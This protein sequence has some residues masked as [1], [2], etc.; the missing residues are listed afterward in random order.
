[1]E[2]KGV[3]AELNT[4]L[5]GKEDSINTGKYK[6]YRKPS[7]KKKAPEVRQTKTSLKRIQQANPL[8]QLTDNEIVALQES[9]TQSNNKFETGKMT[10]H[11][12]NKKSNYEIKNN[13]KSTVT[14]KQDGKDVIPK[15]HT[16]VDQATKHTSASHN[17]VVP[18]KSK[19]LSADASGNCIR[20][21][22]SAKYFET[23]KATAAARSHSSEN[24][25]MNKHVCEVS[26]ILEVSKEESLIFRT[27]SAYQR[28]SVARFT[29]STSSRRS[30][31]SQSKILPTL[32]ELQ[33]RLNGWLLKRG[34]NPTTFAYL[35]QL[36]GHKIG[37]EDKENV[38]VNREPVKAG[39][40]EDLHILPLEPEPQQQISEK[41]IEK[42]ARD[43]LQDL[44]QL[45]QEEYPA[46]HCESWLEL[47]ASKCEK[48]KDDPQYWEC[49]AKI[50][51][52]RGNVGD[53][54]EHYKTA[55]IQGAEVSEVDK[56]LDMLLHKFSLLNI[57][58]DVCDKS[59]IS[60]QK[61][62]I[63][64]ELKDAFKSSVIKFAVQE[65]KLKN[66]DLKI[67]VT[68][69]RRSSRTSHS[70]YTSTPGIKLYNSIT[71]IESPNKNNMDFVKN[72]AL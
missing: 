2:K 15:K 1:M 30:Q 59:K 50:E 44:L 58:N 47:I 24:V 31:Y 9:H 18:K 51:Q 39:S 20:R 64:N 45:I 13:T 6:F 62:K 19:S 61:T 8:L 53:A 14:M 54:I 34:K 66:N 33:R 25:P 4:K 69:V 12:P 37:E 49:R 72:R 38:E 35:Q 48:L 23:K 5:N 52:M 67:M 36:G 68:P 71:E 60:K 26:P 22:L 63:M 32:E 43:A 56:S 40:Y 42:V 10:A 17:T 46:T 16:S 55:I 7:F 21:S 27:P 41:D 3:Q 65:K 70:I 28:R 57:G 29:P 11:P